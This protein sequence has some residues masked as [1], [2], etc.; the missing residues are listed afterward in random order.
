MNLVSKFRFFSNRKCLLK[1]KNFK[2]AKTSK[3]LS[4]G[5]Q[6]ATFPEKKKKN[7]VVEQSSGRAFKML[8]L[9]FLVGWASF[10]APSFYHPA[11]LLF[12]R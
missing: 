11:G 10:K 7:I 1:T 3:L 6:M 2:A 8:A 5:P 4:L 12:G 9:V